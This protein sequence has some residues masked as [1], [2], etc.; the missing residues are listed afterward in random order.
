MMRLWSAV[1]KKLGS[2]AGLTTS[3]FLCHS[4]WKD[5]SVV[6]I[7]CSWIEPPP[8]PTH[9]ALQWPDRLCITG[10]HTARKSSEVLLFWCNHT[11]KKTKCRLVWYWKDLIYLYAQ[12]LFTIYYP[13]SAAFIL[14]VSAGDLCS[15]CWS[16]SVTDHDLWSFCALLPKP[17]LMLF[18]FSVYS[19]FALL[20]SLLSLDPRAISRVATVRQHCCRYYANCNAAHN[21]S[22]FLFATPV[23]SCGDFC[24]NVLLL[25]CSWHLPSFFSANGPYA[26]ELWWDSLLPLVSGLSVWLANPLLVLLLE[27]LVPIWDR[28]DTADEVKQLAPVWSSKHRHTPPRDTKGERERVV[29]NKSVWETQDMERWQ[30]DKEWDREQVRQIDPLI[31]DRPLEMPNGEWSLQA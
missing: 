20:V 2:L 21:W 15:C 9:A 7:H 19:Q 6:R 13:F 4:T 29:Q 27:Q 10:F 3:S 23:F 1:M 16:V 12:L 22:F 5:V 17:K 8:T 25:N 11:D 24:S 30:Q 14:S 28:E 26:G 18:L 31:M